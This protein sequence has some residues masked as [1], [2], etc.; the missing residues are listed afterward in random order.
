MKKIWI[1]IV[2]LTITCKS[3]KNF[4]KEE[5][6]QIKKTDSIANAFLQDRI[7]D[8]KEEQHD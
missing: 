2:L 3:R 7:Q 4:T 1:L 8:L 6:E 5:L